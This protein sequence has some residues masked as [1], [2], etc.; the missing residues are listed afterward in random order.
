MHGPKDTTNLLTTLNSPINNL[1]C[2]KAGPIA[3]QSKLSDLDC[4][5]GDPGSNP[6]EVMCFFSRW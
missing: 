5:Q 4:G 2:L 3:Q 6:S 1:L